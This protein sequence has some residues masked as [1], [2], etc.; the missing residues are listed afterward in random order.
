MNNMYQFLLNMWIFGNVTEQ[1]INN[2]VT[3]GFI[4]RKEADQILATPKE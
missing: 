4:T 1:Q 2:Y 3:K